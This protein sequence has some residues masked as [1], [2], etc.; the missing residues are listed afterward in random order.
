MLGEEG[1][2]YV[3]VH[4]SGGMRTSQRPMALST[5]RTELRGVFFWRFNGLERR[6]WLSKRVRQNKK[7]GIRRDIENLEPHDLFFFCRSIL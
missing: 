4:H 5:A 1:V 3:L 6:K 2:E 7:G